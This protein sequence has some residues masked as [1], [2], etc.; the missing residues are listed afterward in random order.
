MLAPYIT[1][2][3][4][5]KP[6]YR[7]NVEKIELIT[8]IGFSPANDSNITVVN[9]DIGKNKTALPSSSK[10]IA[11]TAK[12]S[13]VGTGQKIEVSIRHQVTYADKRNG[14]QNTTKQ[15]VIL[16]VCQNVL[17]KSLPHSVE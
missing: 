7:R 3:M 10:V 11:Q 9:S 12:A 1:Q 16:I 5:N 6:P 13:K 8:S 15:I 2:Y 14:T 17:A 4:N